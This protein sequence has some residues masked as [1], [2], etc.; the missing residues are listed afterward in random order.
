MSS[1]WL[2]GFVVV[3]FFPSLQCF[4]FQELWTHAWSCED[5]IR[6][7]PCFFPH[8]ISECY[9]ALWILFCTFLSLCSVPFCNIIAVPSLC[10]V[11][12]W[13]HLAEVKMWSFS[14][15]WCFVTFLMLLNSVWPVIKEKGEGSQILQS[16]LLSCEPAM[17]PVETSVALTEVNSS[18]LWI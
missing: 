7:P 14:R 12:Y 16:W 3:F 5:T 15:E 6:R 10:A 1:A 4:C 8:C 13:D 9:V 17:S 11:V 2:V 18:H